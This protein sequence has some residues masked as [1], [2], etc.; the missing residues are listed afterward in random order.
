M[1]KQK[2]ELIQQNLARLAEISVTLT[3]EAGRRRMPLK[4]LLA[5]APG[6]LINLKKGSSEPMVLRVGDVIIASC[7]LMQGSDGS[8]SV[9]IT[10]VH[11]KNLLPGLEKTG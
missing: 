9:R 2:A 1:D 4:E 7:E 6:D 5:M 11:N 10:A 3:V 8:P